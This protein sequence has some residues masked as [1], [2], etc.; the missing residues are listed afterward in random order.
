MTPTIERQQHRENALPGL[1]EVFVL[2]E[3]EAFDED[4]RPYMRREVLVGDE[5]DLDIELR[6]LF[7]SVGDDFNA[8]LLAHPELTGTQVV[9][10]TETGVNEV[11]IDEN[12]L[13][14]L[15]LYYDEDGN[16]TQMIDWAKDFPTAIALESLQ[17]LAEGGRMLPQGKLDARTIQLFTYMVDAIGIRSRA[18]IYTQRMVELSQTIDGP[19]I[20]MSVGSGAAV[21]NID[22]TKRIEDELGHSVFWRFFDID[23]RALGFA[24]T[25]ISEAQFKQSS[26]D[27][28]E[29][30]EDPETG[31]RQF[32]GR[33]FVRAYKE[34][35]E[36]VHVVDAL[37]LW[38]YLDEETAVKFAKHLYDKVKPGG[39]MIVSNMLKGRP[40]QEFNLRGVGW[41]SLYLRDETDLLRILEKA[42]ID[43]K[44]VTMSFSED[45]V[46]VVMEIHK[47]LKD[48]A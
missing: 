3:K 42:G 47:P 22:A 38:E 43:S 33:S 23:P 16:P 1:G 26:V 2:S 27:Y 40:Q 25:L 15:W 9:R 45:G 37:G 12:N 29:V 36:S 24:H 34:A 32:H 8:L 39:M 19:M 10:N 31:E 18:R 48:E 20:V 17:R 30:T 14:G 13:A 6:A 4:G 44:N 11:I 7:A 5:S 35:S 28:G 21:P 41:P 46:Y